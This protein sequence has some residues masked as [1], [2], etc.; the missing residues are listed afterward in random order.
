MQNLPPVPEIEPHEL[1]SQLQSSED[2]VLLDVRESWEL[3]LAHL[4]DQRLVHL[5]LSQL[6]HQ[7]LAAFPED[8]QD[9]QQG[10]V[11]VCHHGVRS[12]Q[13]TAWM[14][15]QGWQRVTSLKGGLNAYARRVDPSI[16]LY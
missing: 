11:V 14:L 6:A 5:P 16:G 1:A 13:V 10:I 12:A 3:A 2:F 15:E 8:L 7:R 9:R 4:E